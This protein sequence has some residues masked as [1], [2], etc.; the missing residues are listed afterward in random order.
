MLCPSFE[1]EE[2]RVVSF[3]DNWPHRV[4]NLNP[5]RMAKAGFVYRGSDDRVFCFYC[6]LSI[7][8]WADTDIPE[9][10][11]AKYWS[12]CAH[13][14]RTF[15]AG[16]INQHSNF[17]IP[18]EEFLSGTRFGFDTREEAADPTLTRNPPIENEEPNITSLT[19]AKECD[20]SQEL[21]CKV[22]FDA[23]IN[24]LTMPCGYCFGCLACTTK[25]YSKEC[26]I[27]RVVILDVNRI[28]IV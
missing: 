26:P 17:R 6:G 7:Y 13:L 22:C 20:T 27:C 4:D 11:H 5:E 23:Q 21:V 28:Y 18:E 1:F 15:G 14:E 8:Q 25:L 9:I 2:A 19:E 3:T 12:A 16:F 10:E 24:A